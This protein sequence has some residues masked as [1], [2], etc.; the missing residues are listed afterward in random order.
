MHNDN[1]L[2][3]WQGGKDSTQTRSI[4]RPEI[5]GPSSLEIPLEI[6]KAGNGVNDQA[7]LPEAGTPTGRAHI[8][9]GHLVPLPLRPLHN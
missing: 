2:L 4:N 8:R 5:V 3:G 6:V 1:T 9:E 7:H